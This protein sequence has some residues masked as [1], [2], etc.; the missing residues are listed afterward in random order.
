MKKTIKIISTLALVFGLAS[1]DILD[2]Y[3]HNAVS[4][5]NVSTEDLELL[6]TG[7]YHYSQYKPGFEGYFQGDMAGGDF[8]RGGGSVWPDAKSWIKDCILTTSG[9]TSV[10]YLGYYSWLYQVNSFIY[11]AKGSEQNSK[12][13]EMLGVAYFFRALIYYNLTSK[14]REVPI[15]RE[16]TNDAIAKSSEGECWAFVN[17]NVDNAIAMC[18]I[19][20]SKNFVSVQ[21][22]KA[23]KAR[24]LLAQGRNKEAALYAEELITDPLFKLDDFDKIFR[25]KTNT[26]EIFTFGNIKEE[27]GFGFAKEFLQPATIYVP[28]PQMLA[29]YTPDDKRKEVSITQDADEMVLNK[30]RNKTTS[31]PIIVFRLAEMYLISAEGKGI[32]EGGL[33]RLNELRAFRGLGSV[34]PAPTNDEQLLDAVIAERRIELLGEGFRWFDLVRTGKYTAT[35]ELEEK[36]TVFP[37]PQREIDLNTKLIQNDLWK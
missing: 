19:Y 25:G 29:L 18:P 32:A 27:G 8:F 33:K 7:L 28:T 11:S 13:K 1:C 9:W 26:E 10:A 6:C 17:E 3:P 22:A 2:Q 36:Y 4:R 15:L 21:A 37:L 16:P 34:S 30:Y 24:A 12:V 35:T 14:Y 23:L 5:D 31:D 20:T